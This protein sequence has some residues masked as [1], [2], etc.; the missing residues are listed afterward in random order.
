MTYALLKRLI[1]HKLWRTLAAATLHTSLKNFL[2]PLPSVKPSSPLKMPSSKGSAY[3]I[4]GFVR[5]FRIEVNVR[6][7]GVPV[8]YKN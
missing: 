3:L 4:M 2:S 8:A 7:V 5:G 1:V 6:N